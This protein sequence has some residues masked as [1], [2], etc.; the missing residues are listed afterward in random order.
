MVEKYKPLPKELRLGFSDIH[1]IG[2]FAKEKIKMGHDFGVVVITARFCAVRVNFAIDN[3][4][5]TLKPNKTS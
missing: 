5:P 3:V 4:I 1:D 2:L